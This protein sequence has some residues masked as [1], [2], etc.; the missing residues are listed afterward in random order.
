MSDVSDAAAGA[1]TVNLS[2]AARLLG[3]SVP[4]FKGWLEKYDDLPVQ[5]RGTNGQPYE[6]DV[7]ALA[8]WRKDR[9]AELAASAVERANE[10]DQMRMDLFGV[11]AQA[12]TTGRTAKELL[13]EIQTQ[14]AIDNLGQR[15]G[16]L[17]RV[18]DVQAC[19]ENAFVALRGKI[20]AIPDTVGRELD[21]DRADREA[22][23]AACRAALAMASADVAGLANRAEDEAE[24]A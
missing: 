19:I 2:E 8:E 5:R 6:F 1:F 17:V 7:R 11:E 13:E 18:A 4:A 24:A 22:I 14:N 21:L 20:M 3:I 10:I 15:R 23:R 16:E 9:D 12:E